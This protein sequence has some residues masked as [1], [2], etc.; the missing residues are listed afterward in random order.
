MSEKTLIHQGS[1]IALYKQKVPLPDNQHTYY[2]L[3]R[4]PGGSVMAAIDEQNRLCFIT[5]PRP[6]MGGD[7]WEFPAGCIDPNEPPAETA[8][9]ELEE[10][11]GMIAEEWFD[12]GS[13]CTAPGYCDEV[14]YLFAARK[15]TATQT[16]FDAEEQIESHWLSVSEADEKIQTGEI[17]DAKTLC[18]LYRLRAHPELGKTLWPV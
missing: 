11:T 3:I 5:Q 14:L 17:Y 16:K 4:H 10:E 6:A 1:H 18:L 13:I 2:D 15:L 7:I 8:K 9:R 12:L